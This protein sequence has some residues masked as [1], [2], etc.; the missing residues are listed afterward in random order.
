MHEKTPQARLKR[1]YV[2]IAKVGYDHNLK[3]PICVKYRFNN[4]K[5]FIEFV[6]KKYIGLCWINFFSNRPPTKGKLVGT[7]GKVKG[8]EMNTNQ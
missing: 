5:Q 4:E 7:W 1:K 6:K 8:L 3:Q 2:G